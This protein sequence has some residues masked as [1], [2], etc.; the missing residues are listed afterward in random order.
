[1]RRPRDRARELARLDSGRFPNGG[2]GVEFVVRLQVPAVAAAGVASIVWVSLSLLLRDKFAAHI[3]F[4]AR[5]AA[6]NIGVE[7][8]VAKLALGIVGSAKLDEVGQL[9][10]DGF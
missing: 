9:F 10:I 4:L 1:M 7:K 5:L 2:R 8:I 6:K 3:G